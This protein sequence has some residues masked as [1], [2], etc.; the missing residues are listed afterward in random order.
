MWNSCTSVLSS[1]RAWE[2]QELNKRTKQ[3][4]EDKKRGASMERLKEGT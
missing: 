4:E 2:E 1:T 3:E